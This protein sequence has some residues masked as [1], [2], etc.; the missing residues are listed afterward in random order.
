VRRSLAVSAPAAKSLGAC[1]PVHLSSAGIRGEAD[2][3]LTTVDTAAWPQA[4]GGHSTR[5]RTEP[6]A[7]TEYP[8]ARFEP[9]SSSHFHH[10]RMV[11]IAADLVIQP[12]PCT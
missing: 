5:V 7:V 12:D 8:A 10:R 3:R 2:D 9:V 6:P 4:L 11:L 1:D